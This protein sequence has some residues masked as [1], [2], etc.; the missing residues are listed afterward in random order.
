MKRWTKSE[1]ND[2]YKNFAQYCP[3]SARYEHDFN[4]GSK[5]TIEQ[6]QL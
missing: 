2:T 6:A 3:Q 5:L 4:S 1:N